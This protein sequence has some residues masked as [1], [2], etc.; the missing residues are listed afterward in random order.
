MTAEITEEKTILPQSAPLKGKFTPAAK[1]RITDFLAGIRS[2]EPTLC[3]LYGD[4]QG[5]VAGRPSWSITA[6]APATVAEMTEMYA[7]F[8][9]VVSYELDG[10]RVVVPQMAHIAELDTGTLDFKDNRLVQTV[11]AAG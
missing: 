1:Q 7:S 5:V 9:A 3:L 11:P 8:G 10:F 2:F 4:V 6:F